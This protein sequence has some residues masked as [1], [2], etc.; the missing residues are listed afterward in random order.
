MYFLISIFNLDF[1]ASI[2]SDWSPSPTLLRLSIYE[3]LNFAFFCSPFN[4]YIWLFSCCCFLL[5]WVIDEIKFFRFDWRS[6][7]CFPVNWRPSNCLA[8][9]CKSAMFFSWDYTINFAFSISSP[10]SLILCTWSSFVAIV[11]WRWCLSS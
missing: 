5:C 4:I 7:I 11:C 8:W 6:S 1:R 9:F 3:L 2:F 10:P